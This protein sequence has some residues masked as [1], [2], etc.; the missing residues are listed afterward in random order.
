[1][2][3]SFCDVLYHTGFQFTLTRAKG[4]LGVLFALRVLIIQRIPCAMR[5]LASYLHYIVHNASI[6]LTCINIHPAQNEAIF[7]NLIFLG[8]TDYRYNL[9][10]VQRRKNLAQSLNRHLSPA[11]NS[12]ILRKT[13]QHSRQLLSI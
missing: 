2:L 4:V 13:P 12:L 11:S 5:F 6:C 9:S 3:F 8:Q 1:M 7:S 10:L